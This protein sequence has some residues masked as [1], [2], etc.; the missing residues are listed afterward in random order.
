MR[1]ITSTIAS[2]GR[3]FA[4]PRCTRFCPAGAP[5]QNPSSLRERL[6]Q[7][8]NVDTISRTLH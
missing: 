1:E 4:D 6:A 2:D 8:S 5:P 3:R 7:L